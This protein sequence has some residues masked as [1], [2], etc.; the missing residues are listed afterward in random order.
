MVYHLCV[1]FIDYD[2]VINSSIFIVIIYIYVHRT[3]IF[4]IITLFPYY[5]I[6]TRISSL[7]SGMR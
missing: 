1:L 7:P 3:S 6:N 2:F 4:T 5:P